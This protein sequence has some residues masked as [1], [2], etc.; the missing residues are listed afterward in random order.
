[1]RATST[2]VGDQIVRVIPDGDMAEVQFKIGNRIMHRFDLPL[3]E[4][5][6][7]HYEQMRYLR[8][9]VGGAPPYLLVHPRMERRL[10]AIRKIVE[11]WR[12]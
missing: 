6:P 12:S 7:S 8:K 10:D 9:L 11:G 5:P 1:M 4:W 3:A 2:H